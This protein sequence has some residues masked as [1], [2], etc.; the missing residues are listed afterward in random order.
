MEGERSCESVVSATCLEDEA[1]NLRSKPMA[2][3]GSSVVAREEI[4]RWPCFVSA[5]TE[6]GCWRKPAQTGGA[7]PR[8]PIIG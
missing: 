6:G 1:T 3:E 2:A 8:P 7:M 4:N 5:H